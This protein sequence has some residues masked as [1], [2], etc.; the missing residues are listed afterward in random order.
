MMKVLSKRMIGIDD[1]AALPTGKKEEAL[2][3]LREPLLAAFDVYKQ[4]IGYGILTETETEHAEIVAWY[5][6]LCDLKESAMR[7]VPENIQKYVKIKRM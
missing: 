2:R 1:T 6:N 7:E 3:T 4:N 5:R